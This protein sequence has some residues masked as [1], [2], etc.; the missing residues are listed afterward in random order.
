MLKVKYFSVCRHQSGDGHQLLRHC[1]HTSSI[2]HD[3]IL[4]GEAHHTKEAGKDL[5]QCAYRLS[6][7]RGL[8]PLKVATRATGISDFRDTWMQINPTL[9]KQNLFLPFFVS[10]FIFYYPPSF[11]LIT[12]IVIFFC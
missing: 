10:S 2:G 9:R 8:Q 1:K 12:L 5:K 3:E 7:D 6:C 11:S 4:E